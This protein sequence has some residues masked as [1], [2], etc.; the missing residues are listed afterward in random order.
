VTAQE[1]ECEILG[2]AQR[3]RNLNVFEEKIRELGGIQKREGILQNKRHQMSEPRYR[4]AGGGMDV[5][6]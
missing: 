1:C 2:R 6:Y 4:D 5:P 3:S